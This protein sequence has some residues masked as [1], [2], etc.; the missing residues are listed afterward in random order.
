[1][2]EELNVF[3]TTG[4]GKSLTTKQE[5]PPKTVATH[6]WLNTIETSENPESPSPILEVEKD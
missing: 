6:K 3:H 4:F 5:W 1:M 2:N